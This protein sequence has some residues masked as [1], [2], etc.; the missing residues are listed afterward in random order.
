[1][2]V[3]TNKPIATFYI[4][5]EIKI[6]SSP[7]DAFVCYPGAFRHEHA[8]ASVVMVLDRSCEAMMKLTA[9]AYRFSGE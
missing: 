7:N 5:G 1:M 9:S 3:P 8:M 6:L 4:L 2:G